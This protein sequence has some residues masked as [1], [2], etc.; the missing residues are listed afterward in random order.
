MNSCLRMLVAILVV[1]LISSCG[2]TGA[3][4]VPGDPSSMQTAP[5]AEASTEGESE[6]ES[7]EESEEA[8]KQSAVE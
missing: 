3:L 8:K 6:G 7:D 5:A 4:Y 2:Q 1:F